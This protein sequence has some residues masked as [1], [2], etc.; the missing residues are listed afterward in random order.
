MKPSIVEKDKLT[1]SLHRGK[2]LALI[3]KELFKPNV[4]LFYVDFTL[5]FLVYHFALFLSCYFWSIREE[6]ANATFLFNTVLVASAFAQL[7]ALLFVH[8]ALHQSQT[9][10]KFKHYY[11]LLFG[12]VSRLPYYSYE[13]HLDHHNP[14]HYGTVKDPEYEMVADSPVIVNFLLVPF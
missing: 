4:V 11:N 1:C 2:L 8:E 6:Q 3:P 13:P 9:L 7:R 14:E 12:C 10:P 5:S